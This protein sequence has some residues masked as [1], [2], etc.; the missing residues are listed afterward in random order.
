LITADNHVGRLI[1]VHYDTAGTLQD[2]QALNA[3]VYALLARMSGKGVF[4]TD[5][6]GFDVLSD[7][8]AT[9][10]SKAYRVANAKVERTALLARAGTRLAEQ[11]AQI[12]RD[13]GSPAR[14]V[15][16]DVG[17]ARRWLGEVLDDAER[18][19]LEKV[20]GR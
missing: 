15:F 19:R 2:H 3:K 7:D 17:E 13:A 11:L 12:V 8:L 10:L 9:R 6:R 1:E 16:V 18:S 14:R 4:C 5:M 20:L